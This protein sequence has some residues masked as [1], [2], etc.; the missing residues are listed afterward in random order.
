MWRLKANGANPHVLLPDWPA[1]SEQWGAQ[2]TPDGR[3]F[4]FSS[5]REGRPNVYELVSPRWFEFW[6]KATAV[7]ITGNQIPILASA[8][9]RD[10]THLYVLGRADQGMMQVLDTRAR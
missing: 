2:W 9:A 4:V 3:H 8:P 6:K 1:T 5:D 7:R 10:S